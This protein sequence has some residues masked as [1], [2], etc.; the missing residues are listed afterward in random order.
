MQ[1]GCESIPDRSFDYSLIGYF[2]VEV[3]VITLEDG[4]VERLLGDAVGGR[5]MG[6]ITRGINLDV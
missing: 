5:L 1:C 6:M 2:E 3:E 4:W